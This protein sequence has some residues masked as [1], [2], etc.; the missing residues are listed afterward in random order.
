MNRMI[1]G[2]DTIFGMPRTDMDPFGTASQLMDEVNEF[3]PRIDVSE[4]DKAIAVHAELPGLGKDDIKITIENGYLELTGEKNFETRT[5]DKSRRYR[6]VER[7]YG[8]FVRRLPVPRGTKPSDVKARFQN[9]VL[10]LEIHKEQAKDQFEVKI[11][12]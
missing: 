8:S 3:V 7:S 10:E 4:T 11:E 2:M 12:A 9:G 6:R 5:D 1:R